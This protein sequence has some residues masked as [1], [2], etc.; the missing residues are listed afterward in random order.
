M[1][2]NPLA[3]FPRADQT[4]QSGSTSNS[5]STDALA[6]SSGDLFLQLL[7]AQLKTQDPTS[8]M[9]P[10][11]MVGQMLSMNQLNELIQIRQLMQGTSTTTPTPTTTTP[12]GA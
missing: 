6:N 1:T 7:I 4:S 9:D 5:K 2:I 8:P 12:T 3:A 10:T 11:Q